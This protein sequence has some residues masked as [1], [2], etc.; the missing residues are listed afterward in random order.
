MLS[1]HKF[2]SSL[3][4]ILFFYSSVNAT[5]VS[6]YDIKGVKLGMSKEIVLKKLP[7]NNP[8]ISEGYWGRTGK[9]EILRCDDGKVELW[10]Q[11]DHKGFSNIIGFNSTFDIKPDFNKLENRVIE[12]YGTTKYKSSS[13]CWN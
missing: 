11:L 2:A 5:D 8:K 10:A 6:I 9:S 1:A 12:K 13:Y 3:L 7:C 4:I